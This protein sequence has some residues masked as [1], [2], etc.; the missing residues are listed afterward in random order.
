MSLG[1]AGERRGKPR[2]P[3]ARDPVLEARLQELVRLALRSGAAD[4]L[5]LSA[6]DVV[7]DPRV[8]F[9]CM[10][11]PCFASGTC[12]HCPP[13][14]YGWKDVESAVRGYGRAIFFRVLVDS[15]IIAGAHVSDGINQGRFDDE[16]NLINLGGHYILVFQVAA[17]LEKRSREWGYSPRGF[18]AGTCRDVLC[19]FHPYCQDLMTD[20]GCRHPDLARP[21][22][23]ACGM[24]VYAMGAAVGWDIYPI[25]G[26]CRPDDVPRG[27]LMGL[28]LVR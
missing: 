22:M 25:G 13:H 10:I 8:R 11:P 3:V 1:R 5:V 15:G 23:E 2:D 17:L 4:A 14:G 19:H 9:K 21:S 7:L 18:A 26:T 16:G 24:D 12:A 6:R 27:S 20:R 28:V